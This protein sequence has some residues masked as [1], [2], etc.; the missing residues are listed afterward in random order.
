MVTSEGEEDGA[1]TSSVAESRVA[2]RR[3]GQG[4]VH[5]GRQHN[6]DSKI[7]NRQSRH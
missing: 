6:L 3:E 7:L 5:Y 4:K 2:T 1:K